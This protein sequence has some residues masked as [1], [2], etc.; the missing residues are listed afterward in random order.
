MVKCWFDLITSGI[1]QVSSQSFLFALP[2]KLSVDFA[3]TDKKQKPI[4][5]E[6]CEELKSLENHSIFKDIILELI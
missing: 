3:D 5:I 6:L 2:T 1:I 4:C